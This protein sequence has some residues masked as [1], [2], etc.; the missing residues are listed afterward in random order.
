MEMAERDM[1][2]RMERP[3]WLRR[4]H[5][6]DDRIHIENTVRDNVLLHN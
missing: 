1:D 6:Y 4:D 2:F 5:M 3:A